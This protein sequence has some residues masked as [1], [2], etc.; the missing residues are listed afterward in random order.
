M[1][2]R[3]M[4]SSEPPHHSR[5]SPSSV[6]ASY[7]ARE[8]LRSCPATKTALLREE[9][10]HVR[11]GAEAVLADELVRLLE[12]AHEGL[13]GQVVDLRLLREAVERDDDARAE[14]ARVLAP[15]E[16]AGV[17]RDDVE[18]HRHDGAPRPARRLAAWRSSSPRR[19]PPPA[20]RRSSPSASARP[21]AAS[22][23]SRCER[24]HSPSA[25]AA[26]ARDVSRSSDVKTPPFFTSSSAIGSPRSGDE[27]DERV[28]QLAPLVG[29]EL[30]EVRGA[31]LARDGG[32]R[33]LEPVAGDR[34]LRR[35]SH[36][37]RAALEE[38][39]QLCLDVVRRRGEEH[40][41]LDSQRRVVARRELRERRASPRRSPRARGAATSST[42]TFGSIPASDCGHLRLVTRQDTL[43][44]AREHVAERSGRGL[45][46]A[47]RARSEARPPTACR[48][49]ARR[50]GPRP[51]RRGGA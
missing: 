31:D 17:V 7:V 16:L 24:E 11:A 22:P 4:E 20:S 10:V 15:D 51:A 42:A 49:R 26:S 29:P 2:S 48:G 36:E 28:H 41:R 43:D 35:H 14:I 33:L 27:R 46:R 19:Q 3:A 37:R 39:H 40:L 47:P 6:A 1:T 45:R 13:V 32:P 30:V 18:A 23:P 50:A 5:I 38:L 25:S 34:A 9:D 21:R 12:L 8:P 44:E